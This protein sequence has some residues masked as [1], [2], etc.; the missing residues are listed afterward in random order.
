MH[1]RSINLLQSEGGREGEGDGDG[2]G[3]GKGEGERRKGGVKLRRTVAEGEKK[4]SKLIW[5]RLG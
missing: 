2:E 5:V 4:Q 3:E 1:C